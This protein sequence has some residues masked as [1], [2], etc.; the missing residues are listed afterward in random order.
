VNSLLVQ[1]E[2]RIMVNRFLD[3]AFF[4]DAGKVTAFRSEL[5]LQHLKHDVGFGVRLHGPL[6]TPLRIEVARG[7]DGVRLIFATS[8]AF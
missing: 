3:T 1:A 7:S 2:W 5:D 6:A 4:Y 8:A